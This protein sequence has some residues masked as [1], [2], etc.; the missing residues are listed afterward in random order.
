MARRTLAA[1]SG[2]DSVSGTSATLE[3]VGS[4]R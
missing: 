3:A 2:V 4:W 1:S